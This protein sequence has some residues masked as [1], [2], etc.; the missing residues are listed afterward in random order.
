MPRGRCA[1]AMRTA[2]GGRPPQQRAEQ[3]DRRRVRPVEVVEH[4]HE[5]PALRKGL[6]Q[7]AHRAMGAIA[8]VLNRRIARGRE[9]RQRRGRRARA[10]CTRL[11]PGRPGSSDRALAGTRPAHRRRPRTAGRARA[12]TRSRRGRAAR[13]HLRARRALRAGASCR[14]RAPRRA[15]SHLRGPDR[16]RQ[17][18]DRA[19]ELLGAPNEVVGKQGHF[20]VWRG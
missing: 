9:R 8:L 10:P 18:L 3:L 17:A 2:A 4:E 5:R 20:V 6:E 16:P 12:P 14:S 15:R 1:S 7:R 19:T 13:V 11:R